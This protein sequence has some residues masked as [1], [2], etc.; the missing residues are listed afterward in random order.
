MKI[1]FSNLGYARG[2]SG[3]LAHHMQYASRHFYIRHAVQN[4]VLAQFRHLLVKEQPELCCMVELDRGSLQSG[5]YNQMT[6]LLDEQYCYSDIA[7]K[8]GDASWLNWMP[9]HG[10]K[11]NGLL[12]RHDFAFK[13]LYFKHGSKRLI[14]QIALP[15]IGTLFFAHFSLQRKVRALQLI[16]MKELIQ[17]SGGP[18]IV[19]ADFNILQ[20]FGELRPLLDGTDLVVLNDPDIPTFTFHRRLL[21]LDLC[22][23]SNELVGQARLDVIPQPY[24]D[25]AALLLEINPTLL[26]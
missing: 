7:N 11:S 3:S 15:D 23:C 26:L 6:A 25:H 19:L 12:A 24:S 14:Y 5:Y 22:L 9:L 8:Y 18:A 13:K 16:E 17:A 10:G 20:G 21:T 2:I 1:I 4:A